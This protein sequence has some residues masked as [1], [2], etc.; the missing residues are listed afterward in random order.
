[1]ECLINKDILQPLEFS[2]LDHCIECIKGKFVKHIKQSGATRSLGVLEIS[3][4]DICGS[5][6]VTMVDGYN[7]FVT[8]TDDFS[9]YGYMYPIH[10]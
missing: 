1:M 4:T 9:C 2:N 3:H 6:N 5:D 10:E 7:P 8:F